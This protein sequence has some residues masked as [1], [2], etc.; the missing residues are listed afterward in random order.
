[1]RFLM[2]VKA[3]EDSESGV[4]PDPS[5]FVE[6]GNYNEELVNAGALFAGEGLL[7]SSHGRRVVFSDTG[8]TVVQGPFPNPTELVAGFWIIEVASW[9]E[10][11]SWARRVP[12]GP[13]GV[14]ELRQ[15]ASAE[16]FGDAVP[17]EVLEQEARLRASVA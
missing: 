6:M 9:D 13:G 14:L 1:M 8:S 2:I 11:E 17:A 12:F 3:S 16:D 10:A 4:L 7:P 15:I 5:L